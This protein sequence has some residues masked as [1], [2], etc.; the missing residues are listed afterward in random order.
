MSA[1]SLRAVPA[2]AS[3][4]LPPLAAT[5]WTDAE[6]EEA[7][8]LWEAEE[9]PDAKWR[10]GGWLLEKEPIGEHGVRSGAQRRL[11][12]LGRLI[13]ASRDYL[14]T[15]RRTAAA[16]PPELRVAEATW[17]AHAA[18]R[19]GGA[20][21]AP[22]RREQMLTKMERDRWGKIT[23]GSVKRWRGGASFGPPNRTIRIGAYVDKARLAAGAL[24][25]YVEK[26]H[27]DK[28]VPEASHASLDRARRLALAELEV[29]DALLAGKTPSTEEL[30]AILAELPGWKGKAA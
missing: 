30:R 10:F 21:E 12:H 20:S 13:D 26:H 28:P 9:A 1:P 11:A 22:R 23:G 2:T 27:G 7:R 4:D 16:W 19:D 18:Y 14:E 5:E 29:I 24:A 6:V 17:A 3:D 25:T 15:L 8:A